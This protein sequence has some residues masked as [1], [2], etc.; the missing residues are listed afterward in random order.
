M[1]QDPA[2]PGSYPM[3]GAVRPMIRVLLVDDQAATR[4]VLRMRLSLEP[5]LEVIGDVADGDAALAV[6]EDLV[7]DVVVID[8][9]VPGLDGMAATAVL[10]RRWPACAVV[11]LS[12]HDTEVARV[13]AREAG[14]VAFVGKHEFDGPLLAAIRRAA[15]TGMNLPPPKGGGIAPSMAYP[16]VGQPP[17]VRATRS[18]YR[19]HRR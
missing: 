17:Q 18:R 19:G 14:A 4:A 8:V 13:A 5:D 1:Y 9:K 3:P 15:E 6:A 11:V 7:P 12:L 2:L 10:R 16:K